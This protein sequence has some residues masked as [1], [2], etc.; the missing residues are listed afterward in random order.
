MWII[1]DFDEYIYK[2]RLNVHKGDASC[3]AEHLENHRT[4]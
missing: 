4:D 2:L 1:S 3:H